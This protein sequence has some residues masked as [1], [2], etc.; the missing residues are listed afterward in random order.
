MIWSILIPTLTER[1]SMFERLRN[2]L[3]KQ[4][5]ELGLQN[6]IEICAIS[7]SQYDRVN[8]ISIGDKRNRL[9]DMA[10]G[11]YISFIDDDDAVAPYY[12]KAIH[13]ALLQGPSVVGIT[14]IMTIN[15]KAKSARRFI[16]SMQHKSYFERSGVYY[17]PPNHLNPMLKSIA[18]MVQF[19][20]KYHGEDTDWAMELCHLKPYKFEVMIENP[21]YYYLYQHKPIWQK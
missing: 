7:D 3:L 15:G 4:I 11:R 16:H 20:D 17:R 12:I 5:N 9:I 14:G 1:A 2:E 21:I 13:G 10:Q 18:Q 8:R 6:E 19:A